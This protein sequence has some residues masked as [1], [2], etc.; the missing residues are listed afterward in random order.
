MSPEEFISDLNMRLELVGSPLL[1]SPMPE[2][3][4]SQRSLMFSSN[5]SQIVI[6]DGNE[7]ARIQTGFESKYGR[8]CVDPAHRDHDVQI[9]DIIPKCTKLSDENGNVIPSPSTTVIYLDAVT[10]EV[11][12]FEIPDCV[13][14]HPGFGYYTKKLN[15]HELVPMNFIPKDM[16]FVTAPNHDEGLYNL[17][18]NANVVYMPLW[19]TTNDA[20]LISDEFQKK[21]THTAV[22]Q[23]V[24]AIDS[25]HIPLNLYGDNENYKIFPDIGQTVRDDGI[26]IAL[27]EHTSNSLIADIT[28]DNLRVPS[29]H[30]D[31]YVA[32]AGAKVVD[33]K[34]F[35]NKS[36]YNELKG[37]GTYKQIVRYQ[38][39][40][41]AYYVTISKCY[42]K[43]LAQGYKIG[44]AFAN[45]VVECK[46]RSYTNEFKDLVLYN[47]K[48]P[49]DLIYLIITFANK[50]MISRGFKLT[51]REGAKGVISDVWKKE[52]M[53]SYQCGSKRVYADIVITGESPFNRLNSS[54]N[55]EQFINYASDIV[56]QRCVDNVIPFNDQ[57]E[58]LLGFI[59]H[60][61]PVYAKYLRE[62][63]GQTIQQKLAFVDE[64]KEHGIY[65]IIPP[66]TKSMT[67]DMILSISKDYQI[68]ETDISF[69][70][71][72][73]SGN[74]YRVD[75]KYKGIIGSKYMFLLGKIPID[76]LSAIEFGYVS[77]FNLPIKPSINDIKQQS[78]FGWTPG[79]YGED[80]T[81]IQT[82]SYGPRLT[83]RILGVYSN[84][85]PAQRLLK[86][87]LLTDPHPTQ[88]NMI[89]MSDE[90]IIQ[91]STVN[92]LFQHMFA[93]CGYKLTSVEGV[94]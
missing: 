35:V 87:H 38:E 24:L 52:D 7:P 46:G 36:K 51:S 13:M 56:V 78:R 44:P 89:E 72:D 76:A 9:L 14:L 16:E 60:V 27:R 3:I 33:V 61:R 64:I 1:L 58:Y 81:S 80:E 32:P 18:V 11:G 10:E 31:V 20:F 15:Q 90:E 41:N 93:A 59:E 23:I 22:D 74:R 84:C 49:V 55:Y 62:Q 21:M 57:Y 2:H 68:D 29:L 88:L 82:V 94:E 92:A 77:Q 45:H 43:Y 40:Y 91:Q 25:D 37:I 86:H 12:Y 6:V 53:P 71:Y 54:Q 79:R 30:D 19:G 70:Q 26:V 17:G 66:F 48:D 5:S 75:G 4:S 69:Y 39:S 42:E 83:C 28:D 8:Y 34:V 47:K 85:V 50:S 65:Y 73:K 63:T 67:P